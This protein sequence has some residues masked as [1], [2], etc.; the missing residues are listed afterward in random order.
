MFI[1]FYCRSTAKFTV[2]LQ[3]RNGKAQGRRQALTTTQARHLALPGSPARPPGSPFPDP[4]LTR[5]VTHVYQLRSHRDHRD[6]RACRPVPAQALN[7]L[8]G[9]AVTR[10]HYRRDAGPD[11]RAGASAPAE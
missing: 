1:V 7:H 10:C 4:Q 5:G 3:H 6:H 9:M 11:V 8:T 2:G